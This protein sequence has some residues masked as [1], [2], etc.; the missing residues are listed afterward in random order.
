MRGFGWVRSSQFSAMTALA[1]TLCSA[2]LNQSNCVADTYANSQL[3]SPPLSFSARNYAVQESTTAAMAPYA[4]DTRPIFESIVNTDYLARGAVVGD[5]TRLAGFAKGTFLPSAIPVAGQPFFGTDPRATLQGDGSAVRL[6]AYAPPTTGIPL[7]AHA[8]IAVEN[9]SF[10]ATDSTAS[11]NFS[12]R[13][14]FAQLSRMRVGIM[15]SA[16]SDPSAVPET[17]DIAGPN[18]RI[19]VYDAGLSGGQGR[20]SYD[21]ISDTPEGFELIGSIE[22]AIPEVTPAS[23]DDS[24]FARYP[25]LICTTQYVDGDWIKGEFV[26]R[27]HVQFGNVFRDIGVESP[28]ASDVTAFGWGMALSGAY[29][30]RVNPNITPLDRIMFSVAYGKGI[31][32]YITDLN[33]APDAGDGVVLANGDLAPSQ[34]LAWYTAYC[35]NWTDSLRSTATFSQVNLDSAQP[36][37]GTASPY[38]IG[39]YVAANL[40]YHTTISIKDSQT[41]EQNFFTGFEYLYGNKEVLSGAD[42]E[43]HRLMFL[44]AVSK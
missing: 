30:F 3:V 33:A 37:L 6:N 43:A 7:S 36:G 12:V 24:T 21:F 4:D 23:D 15:D 8:Q 18:A 29:R 19:T 41:P 10:S 27:W 28:D 31:S 5:S 20:L 17:L 26:E 42:G 39:N 25:D 2:G 11:P 1:V 9:T 35:H 13:Q 44:V 22:E 14:A 16:F 38:R 40:V 32:H 34:A